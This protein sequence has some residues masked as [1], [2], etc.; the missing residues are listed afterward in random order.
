M[1]NFF[2]DTSNF[3]PFKKALKIIENEP[4]VIN[5]LSDDPSLQKNTADNTEA[6]S[7]R[8]NMSKKYEP[9]PFG[10]FFGP[11]KQQA[12]SVDMKDFSSWRN[13]NY[14]K[15]EQS[16]NDTS[17]NEVKFSMA[18]FMS[19]K[20][21]NKFNELDQAKSDLQKPINQLA[22][23]DPLYKKFSLDS[24]MQ[25]LEEQT[26]VKGKFEENDDILEPLGDKTQSVTPDS[27]QDENFGFGSG[28]NIEKLAFD[29]P[30]SGESFKFEQ[31]ELDKVRT[32]LD[33]LERE[34]AHIKEKS[35][36]KIINTN[37]LSDITASSDDFDIAKLTG[38]DEVTETQAT[39]TSSDEPKTRKTFF[40]INKTSEPYAKRRK[41]AIAPTT[42]TLINEN[43]NL[44]EGND[45]LGDGQDDENDI[46]II[47]YSDDE[48]I[49]ETDDVTE[50]DALGVISDEPETA[51]DVE[52]QD[53]LEGDDGVG[54][55]DDVQDNDDLDELDIQEDVDDLD[56]MS[57]ELGSEITQTSGVKKASKKRI[58]KSVDFTDFGEVVEE[59]PIATPTYVGGYS[60]MQPD[61]YIYPEANFISQGTT[62][63]SEENQQLKAQLN[64][65]IESNKKLD[66][67]QQKR[68][69]DVEDEKA[70]V[71]EEYEARIKEMEKSFKQNY[72]DFK[73]QAYLDKLDRDIKLKEAESKFKKKTAQIKE[74]EKASHAKD[75]TGAM[76]RKELKSHL[77]ISN[78]EMDKKLLEVATKLNKN[79]NEKLNAEK[80]EMAKKLETEAA[81][82]LKAEQDLQEAK[83][84]SIEDDE[85]DED[86]DAPVKTKTAT[87]KTTTRKRKT[88]T[89]RRTT[90][91]KGSRR[92]IDSDIIGGIDFE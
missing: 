73:K 89:T 45:Y 67:E 43:D 87:R 20:S 8:K 29:D 64:E 47:P 58:G 40:E 65:L 16:I 46:N 9:S 59:P 74:E 88:T 83:E 68:L 35:T 6:I 70:R 48:Q 51:S 15:A 5:I 62:G 91:R 21:K 69:K 92:K 26:K 34:A 53:D 50:E 37:E 75:K 19:E 27:S 25:K 49:D 30:I 84:A 44:D 18:D 71:A 77:N 78:L 38:E 42:A 41:S 22:T 66:E 76:L 7:V 31:E 56:D 54:L 13:K 39:D 90:A 55:I 72:E 80:Q 24:Y 85:D 14:R 86:E 33:K 82:R 11:R 28:M 52:E 23:D 36:Q 12:T 1:N 79:E 81:I 10:K 32:R 17:L 2:F 3:S 60:P 57:D 4:V 63:F 61:T